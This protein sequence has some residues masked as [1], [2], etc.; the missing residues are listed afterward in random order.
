[1]TAV[2][3]DLDLVDRSVAIEAWWHTGQLA[4]DLHVPKWVDRAADSVTRLAAAAGDRG[5]AMRAM[6]SRLLDQW[7]ATARDRRGAPDA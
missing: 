6:A 1:M 7:H 2:E 5:P 3:A 4:A